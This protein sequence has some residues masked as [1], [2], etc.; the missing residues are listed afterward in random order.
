[1]WLSLPV[2]HIGGGTAARRVI[3]APAD[4]SKTGPN[5][6]HS[7]H[8]IL[9]VNLPAGTV[10]RF[11]AVLTF[12]VTS[13]TGAPGLFLEWNTSSGVAK[14]QWI[15]EGL[16]TTRVDATTFSQASDHGNAFNTEDL[17]VTGDS[18]SGTTANF[19]VTSV[20]EGLVK[21]VGSDATFGP[22]W[23]FRTPAAAGTVTFKAGSYVLIEAEPA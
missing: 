5:P 8:P 13:G 18:L 9:Q 11:R 4:V 19:I 15:A 1:M 10:Y 21:A 16:D 7:I 17:G 22:F 23:S 14:I 20:F 12:K 2:G 3:Y 6:A